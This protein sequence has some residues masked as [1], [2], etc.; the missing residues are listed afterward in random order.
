[1]GEGQGGTYGPDDIV[2]WLEGVQP[3]QL[4]WREF[5]LPG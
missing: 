1:M 4:P 5:S 2:S 3:S